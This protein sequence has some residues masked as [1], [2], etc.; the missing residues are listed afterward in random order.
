MWFAFAVG[1]IIATTTLGVCFRISA[2][3][4]KDPRSLSFVYNFTVF[5]FSIILLIFAGFGT[6]HLSQY[7]VLLLVCSGLGYGIFQRF[8]F[9][10]R[11]H[12]EASQIALVIAPTGLVGYFLAI[13]WLHEPLK[14]VRLVGYG[15]V[16]LGALLV[17]KKPQKKFELNKYVLLALA[18]GACL[19]VAAV[20]D[21]RVAPHFSSVAFYVAILWFAQAS[22]SYLPHVKLNDIKSKN[23]SCTASF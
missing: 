23:I 3:K 6:V 20:L 1:F 17:I 14:A 2:L 11:K 4:T 18:I 5:L 8:Q 22:V 19:S 13:I 15:L 9:V 12:I 21:R 7:L 16:I 10:P